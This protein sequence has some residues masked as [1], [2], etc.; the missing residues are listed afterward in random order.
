MQHYNQFDLPLKEKKR[1]EKKKK[2][3]RR[4][5]YLSLWF[6]AIVFYNL[7]KLVSVVLKGVYCSIKVISTAY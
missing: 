2:R 3:K 5:L 4:L 6:S 1:K 7:A